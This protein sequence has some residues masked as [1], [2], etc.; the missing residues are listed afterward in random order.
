MRLWKRFMD[1]LTGHA[2]RDLDR[3]LRA[4]LDA[5]TEERREAGLAASEA[6]YAARR[7]FGN[8]TAIQEQTR[9][10]WGW[11]PSPGFLAGFDPR[12]LRLRLP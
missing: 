3:E 7:A 4:H 8:P 2:D 10:A 12:A 1:W 11:S 6:R 5:E 9:A